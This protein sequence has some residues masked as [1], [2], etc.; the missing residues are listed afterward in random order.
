MPIL[1]KRERQDAKLALADND[2]RARNLIE[3]GRYIDV[4][5]DATQLPTRY[6]VGDNTNLVINPN[7]SGLL[8]GRPW[9]STTS[10]YAILAFEPKLVFD[11]TGNVFKTGGG[12]STFSNSITHA[13]AGNATM[14]D[15]DGLLKWAPHNLLRYSEDF[16][17]SGWIKSNNGSVVVDNAVA[18][19]GTT[20]A[21]TLTIA[22]FNSRIYQHVPKSYNIGEKYTF[23]FWVRSDTVTSIPFGIQG[24]ING[25]NNTASTNTVAPVTSTWN[26]VEFE[27]TVL[28]N[29]I[30]LYHLIGY[31]HQNQA[32]TG[33][34]EIWH[35]HA[36]RSDLGGMVNN[37]AQST[38]L[39]TYV[40]TTSSAVYLPR[41]GHHIYN[42]NAWVNEG[43]LHESEARTNLCNHSD[44]PANWLSN[45][46]GSFTFTAAQ[47][48][49]SDGTLSLTKVAIGNTSTTPHEIYT[50]YSSIN[51]SLGMTLSAELKNGNQRYVMLRQYIDANDWFA[52]TFDLVTGVVTQESVGSTG[53]VSIRSSG[54][55][56]LANGLYRCWV[57]YIGIGNTSAAGFPTIDAVPS[58][59]P[60]LASNGTESY[61]G[62][63]GTHFYLGKM[64]LEQGATPSSY[65]PTS[66]SAATRAAETL[67]VPAANL[68]YNSTNMSIQIDGKI[69]YADQDE[70]TAHQFMR[71]RASGSDFISI[72]GGTNTGDGLRV[73]FQQVAGGVNDTIPTGVVYNE[74]ILVPFNLS[75]RHGSTFVNGAV[76]GTALTADTTVTALPDLSSTD[77]NLGYDFMGTIAQ[78]RM[79]D[80]DLTDA[81]IVEAT[82]PSTE[83]SLQLTFDGSST[84]SFTV[85]DWSE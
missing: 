11:F 67:T 24:G 10:V 16:S 35:P 34:V 14:T 55:I 17:N 19:D 80:E 82:E 45:P 71:W 27:F 4:S 32:Q 28:G 22:Q 15:A 44:N 43:V 77:L 1:T 83:P 42:G 8:P 25:A 46:S 36:Y 9:N 48:V 72:V 39:E 68:P 20:T 61:S 65:I 74:G 78:F 47:A 64:Q 30:A 7:I 59:T 51:P 23:A 75:S 79:W 3:P 54:V 6:A 31:I 18:P 29:D 12:I 60:T 26:L 57:S 66:G 84:N 76:D 33:D 53:S 2:R 58:G 50:T 70:F 41:V 63:V 62:T 56:D 40:P 21:S 69:T 13:R 81:G 37:S 73:L 85:L 52:V 49:G 38:G 5:A